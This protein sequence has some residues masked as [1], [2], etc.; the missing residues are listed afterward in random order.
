MIRLSFKEIVSAEAWLWV[1]LSG[2]HSGGRET[3]QEM[4]STVQVGGDEN[5]KADYAEDGTIERDFLQ[6]KMQDLVPL[7]I[8]QR[9]YEQ[10]VQQPWV[11]GW[12]VVP[13]TW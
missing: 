8:G 11:P 4:V 6:S 2:D 3:H 1:G 7:N 5:L 10:S 9:W 13:A 12:M